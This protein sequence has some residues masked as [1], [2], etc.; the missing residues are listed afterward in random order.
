MKNQEI[1]QEEKAKYYGLK[2]KEKQ[3]QYPEFNIPLIVY[4]PVNRKVHHTLLRYSPKR[5]I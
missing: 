3:K 4:Y 1:L 5:K 2:I